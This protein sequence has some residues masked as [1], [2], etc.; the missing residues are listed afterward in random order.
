MTKPENRGNTGKFAPGQT[1]NPGGRPKLPEELKEAFK[2]LAP[3]ALKTL[4]HVMANADRDSDRVKAAEVI[5]DRGYG[6][7]TQHIDAN[8]ESQIQVINVGIPDFLKP[9]DK[10]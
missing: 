4:A 8:V 2:A 9:D 5:L 6:K 7:A 1:G 10:S 3:E